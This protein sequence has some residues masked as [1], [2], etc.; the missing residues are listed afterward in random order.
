MPSLRH[1]MGARRSQFHKTASLVTALALVAGC[2]SATAT[3]VPSAGQ[4]EEPSDTTQTTLPSSPTPN[5]TPSDLGGPWAEAGTMAAART[6]HALLLGDGRVLVVGDELG[7]GRETVS[8]Q[9]V[10]AELWDPAT[11]VWRMTAS[12]SSPRAD[13]AAVRLA[14]GR[15]LVIGGRN[16]DDQSFSSA[17][18]YDPRPGHESWAKVGLL[19]TARTAP[20]A[21]VMPDGRVLVAGGYYRIEPIFGEAAPETVLA[22]YRQASPQEAETAGPR[23]ADSAP[24]KVGSA[25]ATAELFDPTTGNWVATGPLTFARFGAASVTLA[26]GRILVVG[27]GGGEME[28][29]VDAGA[30]D[31]AEI[32][33]PE[34]GRFSL[35]GRLPGIDRSAIE[36]LSVPLP[37]TDP[38]P[39]E[40]GTLVALNDGGAL[41]IGHG[42][43]WKHEGEISRSFR[44]DPDSGSWREVGQPFAI[45]W[46][47]SSGQMHQ[48]PGE[49]RWN[50][51][52]VP[53]LDGRVLVAGG[54]GAY[55]IAS[56]TTDS[57]ELYDPVADTWSS[58]P[59]MP[60]ARA[61]GAA[62]VLTD[63]SV[64]LVGGYRDLSCG[65]PQEPACGT[66]PDGDHFILASATRFVPQH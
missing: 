49:P 51:L 26:D 43:W 32:Y 57:A 64:L 21:A 23:L 12:L 36:Q 39:A 46:D 52:V 4:S 1:A 8:D 62:V 33:D 20:I 6:G 31:S 19:G 58:V 50:A 41:L 37:E 42:G 55:Q 3:P 59:P 56:L 15:V 24:P 14:D 53:L 13:F 17:V 11:G 29:G 10:K 38:L 9:S 7:L 48:T 44:F 66:R 28:A 27:S 22:A 18:V 54:N 60:E 5:A 16:Q 25:M 40:N 47:M 63:G 34:T 45:S 35:T 30:Y 61:G 2:Q 65:R